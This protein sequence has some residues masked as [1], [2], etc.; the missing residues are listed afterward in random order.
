MPPL[1]AIAASTKWTPI[2]LVRIYKMLLAGLS[3]ADIVEELGIGRT[4]YTIW[5]KRK[6]ELRMVYLMVQEEVKKENSLSAYLFQ[7]LPVELQEKWM[8]IEELNLQDMGSQQVR[9]LLANESKL[10]KQHL[11]LHA[12]STCRFSASKACSKVAVTKPEYDDWCANDVD[13]AQMVTQMEWHKANLVEEK[14]MQ[15]VMEGNPKAII[16]AAGTLLRDRGY[17]TKVEMDVKHSG[18]I[19]VGVIDLASLLPFLRDESKEDILTAF[20]KMEAVEIENRKK[21]NV[22]EFKEVIDVAANLQRQV[23]NLPD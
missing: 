22:L 20:E 21:G 10:V 15:L 5:K 4:I 19:G 9:E 3:D 11:F 17:G 16:H 1:A 14:Y 6:P 7:Q 2:F 13:F 18:S 12:L 23:A 8:R